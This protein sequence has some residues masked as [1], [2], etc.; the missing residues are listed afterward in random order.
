M[1]RRIR[2][3]QRLNQI[4]DQKKFVEYVEAICEDFYAGEW[5]GM[6]SAR[7]TEC[8]GPRLMRV[9]LLLSRFT[10]SDGGITPGRIFSWVLVTRRD[11]SHCAH[12]DKWVR[13]RT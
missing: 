1:R 11:P 3:D 2:S 8:I 4:L 10:Y 12:S 5:A 13:R 6:L 9:I 7:H